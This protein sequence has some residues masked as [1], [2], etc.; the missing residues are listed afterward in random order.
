METS[1]V[2]RHPGVI[3]RKQRHPRDQQG[4]YASD[5][6]TSCMS[7]DETTAFRRENAVRAHQP[8]PKATSS[9]TKE[10]AAQ[11]RDVSHRPCQFWRRRR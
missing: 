11:W 9:P 8:Y 5:F 10:V 3:P 2:R 4:P 7:P 6:T 1:R